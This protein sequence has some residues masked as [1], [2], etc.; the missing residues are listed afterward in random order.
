[1]KLFTE[2]EYKNCKSRG[3][4]PIRCEHCNKVF[5]TT[6][7]N[8]Q[9]NVRKVGKIQD[10]CSQRCNMDA[11]RTNI[12]DVNCD[13]CG[14]PMR[15]KLHHIRRTNHNFCSRS[16]SVRYNNSHKTQ[17]SRISKLEKWI[18]RKLTNMFPDME[19]HFNRK[20][21]INSELDIYIPSIKLAFELNGIFHYE[22]IFGEDKLHAT[23]KNDQ[24]KIKECHS[25]GI[26][27]CVIDTSS[28]KN[29]KESTSYEFLDIILKVLATRRVLPAETNVEVP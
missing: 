9:D 12:V 5:Y 27:L 21:T 14:V 10:F 8:I 11:N 1:M 15:K 6:K 19:F 25:A 24:K 26:Y 13:Q 7:K 28:Q 22:P 20:D 2:E 4:L 29:F 23:Q 17:G 18:S 3:K 16:C